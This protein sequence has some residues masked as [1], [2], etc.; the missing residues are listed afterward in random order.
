[1]KKEL[2]IA[3]LLSLILLLLF[4]IVI[5]GG[6]WSDDIAIALYDSYFIFT[7]PFVTA[8]FSGILLFLFYWIRSGRFA[9][10]R[11]EANQVLLVLSGLVLFFHSLAFIFLFRNGFNEMLGFVLFFV[12]TG[13]GSLLFIGWK[14][15]SIG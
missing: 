7:P 5:F 11:K 15:S 4:R 9:Y 10:R 6:A 1:M 13:L 8:W 3:A 12:G 14:N 2:L